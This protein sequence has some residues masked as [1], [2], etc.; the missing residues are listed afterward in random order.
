MKF[1]IITAS[2][3][4]E[5]TI[6]DTLDS[7][8]EQT[9][10]DFEILVIDGD[11]TDSTC[12]IVESYNDKRIKLFSEKDKG[13]YYAMNKGYKESTGDFIGFLNSDDFFAH[14]NVLKL[15]LDQFNS[16]YDCCYGDI[17]YV[18]NVSKNLCKPVRLWK[19]GEYEKKRLSLGWIPPHPSFYAK[20]ELF[21]RLGKFDINYKFASDFDL[22]CRFISCDKTRIKYL[23]GIQVKMRIGGITNKSFKNI[24][25]GN[26]EILNSLKKNKLKPVTFFFL[27]KI[28]E[29]FKQYLSA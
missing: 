25:L 16:G 24:Y 18:T 3:N 2:F 27:Y 21:E 26:K 22:I 29:R 12:E 5:S 23:E 15:Y 4:S 28:L 11:S 7:I 1:S 13:I 8:M 17:Q 9:F 6:R 20:R 14:T 19:S 10:K